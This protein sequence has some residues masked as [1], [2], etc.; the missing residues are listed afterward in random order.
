MDRDAAMCRSCGA[1]I[2]FERTD[3]G[4]MTPVDVDTGESH[5]ATCPFAE[6]HKPDREVA[7]Q[8]RLFR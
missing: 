1:A 8:G 6:G 2:V 5:W 3:S 4:K 7:G